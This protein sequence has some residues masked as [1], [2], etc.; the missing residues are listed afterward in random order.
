VVYCEGGDHETLLEVSDA[1]FAR[2]M[3]SARLGTFAQERA[4]EY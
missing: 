3:E 2:L 4:T 1:D